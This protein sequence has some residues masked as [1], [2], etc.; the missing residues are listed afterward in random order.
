MPQ[1]DL[2]QLRTQQI[3]PENQF[4][5]LVKAAVAHKQAYDPI[6]KHQFAMETKGLC[7]AD[8]SVLPFKNL[9]RPIYPIDKIV[10]F[11]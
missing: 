9:L 1:M 3:I 8:L 4:I 2:G 10:Q 5:I 7:C 6:A 11:K